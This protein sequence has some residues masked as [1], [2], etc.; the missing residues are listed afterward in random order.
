MTSSPAGHG[1]ESQPRPDVSIL[2]VTYNSADMIERCLDSVAA[3]TSTASYEIV[4]VDNDS[5]DDTAGVVKAGY[6][7]V[8]LDA[9]GENL[10]FG[11]G[12]NRAARQATG[13]Y[14]LLLNPDTELRSPAIDNLVAFARANPGHGLYG[15]RTVTPDGELDPVSC[16]GLP[17]VWSTTCFGLGLSTIFKGSTLFDPESLGDW[18]RDSV[19][20]VPMIT[21]CLELIEREAWDRLGGFDERYWM[22]CEDTDLSRRARDLGYRPIVTPDA[23][24]M[25]EL[26]ASS[27]DRTKMLLIMFR[28]KA[29]YLRTH[30]SGWRQAVTM[31]MLQAGVLLRAVGQAVSAIIGRKPLAEQHYVNL[32]KR[33]KEWTPGY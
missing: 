1:S 29:T 27:G 2:I 19:R 22:Y 28:G 21:G 30:F 23:E 17:T 3:H 33:R 13:E 18:Q 15:G 14:L 20:E 24:V 7:E 11:K 10:G 8:V 5:P 6:P 16:L 12:M 25:H 9:T 4:I 31:A 26:G 32:V